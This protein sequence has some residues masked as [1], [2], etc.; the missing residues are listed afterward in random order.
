M[1]V[2]ADNSKSR[3]GAMGVFY[4]AISYIA[5]GFLPIYWKLLKAVPAD[6][7]LAHR[8]F[9]SFLFV[10]G[11]L[12]YKKGLGVVKETLKDRKSVRNILLCA[13]FITINWGTYI[14]AV[15]S[16]NILQSSMGYYI[17]PLMVVLLG[18]TVLKERLNIFQLVSIACA[19]VGV[20]FIAVQYGRV[21]WIALLLAVTFALY[22]LFKKLLKVESLVGLFLETMVLMPLALGYIIFKLLSGQSA[23]YNVTPTTIVILLFSGIATATPLL[24]Y[25]MGA[26]RVKLS[27]M[28]FLQ[29]ISPTISLILGVFVYRESFSSTHLLSFSCIWLGLI[30]YS[31]SSF[32]KIIRLGGR[33]QAAAKTE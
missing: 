16:G 28:G 26:S 1:D 31:L 18:V 23:L 15:N 24:W 5:W 22:G 32:E 11:I 12:L 29:Y 13:F 6:E 17:N 3:T 8:I 30:I 7:L 14:W 19:A 20:V 21:P 9:W 33:K 2:K 4:G 25:A 10:G 27:T